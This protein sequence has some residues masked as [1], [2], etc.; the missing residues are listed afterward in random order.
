MCA[1]LCLVVIAFGI[2]WPATHKSKAERIHDLEVRVTQLEV[3]V[4][5]LE[6]N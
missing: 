5:L 2:Y 3:R 6:S 1:F 4:K